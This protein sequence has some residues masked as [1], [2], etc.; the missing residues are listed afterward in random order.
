MQSIDSPVTLGPGLRTAQIAQVYARHGRVHVTSILS[1]ECASRVHQCLVSEIPWQLHFNDGA[2]VYD[3]PNESL[4]DPDHAQLLGKINAN[5][6]HGFQYLFNN[7][8]LTDAYAAGHHRELYVMRVLEFL[9]SPEFLEFGRQVTGVRSI[10][11]VDAQA[12]L[13]RSGHFLTS[14][15]DTAER[16]QRVAAYVLNFTPQWR[17]DWGGIL[18]FLDDDGHVAEGYAPAYNALNLFRVPQRHAVS[19]VTPFAPQGRYSISGWL[20]EAP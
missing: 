8:P 19:F 11:L 9:N 20:R 3:L 13:Y 16:K 2:R 4:P 7:F 18:N 10:A 6:T 5:A 15:D 17:T 12:T 14:H 1:A